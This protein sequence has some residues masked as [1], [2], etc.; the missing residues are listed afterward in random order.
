MKNGTRLLCVAAGAAA[1]SLLSAAGSAAE[2]DVNKALYDALKA[3][4]SDAQIYKRVFGTNLP[5]GASFSGVVFKGNLAG[6]GIRY[7]VPNNGIPDVPEVGDQGNIRNCGSTPISREVSLSTTEG[8]SSNWSV[9]QGFSST[10]GQEYTVGAEFEAGSSL[11][12][13]TVT[14]S[15]EMT[16][17]W[18]VT[19]SQEFNHGAEQSKEK[20]Y[21]TTLS[22]VADPNKKYQV[23]LLV[24]KRVAKNVPFEAHF[25]ASG[26]TV[27]GF[28][29]AV[30]G[31]EV[32]LKTSKDKWLTAEDDKK[33][34]TWGKRNRT[35]CDSWERFVIE[36]ANGG[37][38][39]SGDAVFVRTHFNR[40][41]SAQ[42]NGKLEANRT[43]KKSWEQ[44]TIRKVKGSS[45]DLIS[46]GDQVS[47]Q[48]SHGK[49]VVADD[50]NKAHADRKDRGPWETFT[51][52][53]ANP[54]RNKTVK[55]ESLLA[56]TERAIV[57]KGKFNGSFTHHQD[58]IWALDFDISAECA[59]ERAAAA[60]S[61]G[62]MVAHG[63]SAV[64][65]SALSGKPG[66]AGA[67]A[68]LVS[69]SKASKQELA[70]AKP[71]NANKKAFKLS[72]AKK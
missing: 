24:S 59:K 33:T 9:T 6:V 29:E 56:E 47:F 19:S 46:S 52:T 20:S 17:S 28:K 14:A 41:W 3:K 35:K 54:D 30:A 43:E 40:Y 57:M 13:G 58:D 11:F 12:G 50:D 31:N 10:V 42:D 34:V 4:Y 49:Y 8:E 66:K 62:S 2:I 27:I 67:Q 45:G 36:D 16:T 53:L 71:L 1:M 48:G 68:N 65:V 18:E 15:A 44:F 70:K 64:G 25:R 5:E 26:D 22:T 51:V 7:Q 21:T 37:G 32:C 55:L 38:L 72:P 63:T 61:T 60:G 23:Q 69:V 39:K